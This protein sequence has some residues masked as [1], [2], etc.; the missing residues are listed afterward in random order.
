MI[1]DIEDI[2]DYDYGNALF[3]E[4]G[5]PRNIGYVLTYRQHQLKYDSISL[6]FY[7]KDK[8]STFK[9]ILEK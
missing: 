6:N 4:F 9:I 7:F 8:A 1:Q 3:E 2:D 5:T